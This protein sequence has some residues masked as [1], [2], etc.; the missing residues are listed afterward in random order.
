MK[1]LDFQLLD[2]YFDTRLVQ[3]RV[4]DIAA[5]RDRRVH[6]VNQQLSELVYPVFVKFHGYLE[7]KL[8]E[9]TECYVDRGE[10]AQQEKPPY[11]SFRWGSQGGRLNSLVFAGDADTGEIH[12]TWHCWRQSIPMHGDKTLDP[13]FSPAQVHAMLEELIYQFPPI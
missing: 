7:A 4:E 13:A 3:P 5:D 12:A 6:R 2:S 8:G 1:S 10:G 9:S 11:V